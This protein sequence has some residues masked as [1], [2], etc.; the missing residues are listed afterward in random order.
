MNAPRAPVTSCIIEP[1]ALHSQTAFYDV[2]KDRSFI[3]VKKVSLVLQWRIDRSLI[4]A[5][6]V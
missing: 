2:S 6:K 4:F 5:R 3:F 1:N